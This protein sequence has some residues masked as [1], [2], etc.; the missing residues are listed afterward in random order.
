MAFDVVTFF[1]NIFAPEKGDVLTI[2]YDTPHGNIADTA[3][4][5]D[6]RAIATNWQEQIAAKANEWG[7]TVN[8][9]LHYEATGANNAD[10][11]EKGTMGEDTVAIGDV[12]EKTTICIAM[13]QF[14][15][16]APLMGYTKSNT[17]L[18]VGSMPG[19]TRVMEETGLA[20]D[21]NNVAEKCRI[22]APMFKE[23]V[24]AE[25]T[26]ETGHR[27]TFDIN[28]DNAIYLDDGLL[29]PKVAGTLNALHNLPAG[30]TFMTPNEAADSKTEGELPVAYGDERAVFV[31][32]QN[33]IVDIQGD[34]P[35]TK[36]ARE[37]ILADKAMCNIAEVA[38][39]CNDK[40]TIIGSVLQDEKAGFH[41]A[42]G[43]S[44]HIGGTVGVKDFNS[45]E[46]VIHQD[47]VYAKDSPITCTSFEL[48]FPDGKRKQ[49]VK[50]GEVLV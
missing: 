48:I 36:A 42:Y 46:N 21:Y 30:E 37:K 14:S 50:D 29:P 16:T 23:A 18:R 25:A 9:L 10:F 7:I 47:I 22:M 1:Q 31:I 49:L 12:L 38:V 19:M 27:C 35:K 11:P 41:W 26:F 34:G 8:P 4:W 24:S 17:K 43:R 44:D 13:P 20:A 28:V 45:P 6:R 3:D 15:A 5:K 32:K 39:G 2:L 40:A 33:R